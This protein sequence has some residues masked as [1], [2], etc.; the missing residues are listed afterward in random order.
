MP[1]KTLATIGLLVFVTAICVLWG[2][3]H[4]VQTRTFDPVDMPVSLQPGRIQT[5]AFEIN[6]PESYEVFIHFDPSLDDYY[7]E[8][9]CS[10]KNLGSD[11]WKVFRLVRGSSTERQLWASYND[12][13]DSLR[14]N[15]FEAVPGRY[16]VEW[17]VPAGAAC[18]NI[19]HP[20]LHVSTYADEYLKFA[21]LTQYPCLFIGGTGAML[22]L[23]ALFTWLLPLFSK[24]QQL[25]IFPE[26]VLKN[27]I[28]PRRHRPIPLMRDTSNFGVVWG[29]ILY[30]LMFLFAMN[31]P[32]PS[33]GLLLNLKQAKSAAAQPS[34]WAEMTSVYISPTQFYVNGKP[35]DRKELHSKLLESLSKQMV[36]TVYF[37]AHGDCTFQE[38]AYAMDTIQ[39]LG[40]KVVWITPKIREALAEAAKH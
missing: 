17:D 34:P 12:S 24:K 29:S 18:L 3:N 38:A 26:L 6:L 23:R 22:A 5:G 10:Y 39:G 16:E 9:R 15:Q 1:Q 27:V 20:R 8:G 28:A 14:A 13:D 25:R 36:W 35:I 33:F 31:T 30:V 37:E 21:A 32:A 40:A 19:R 4:W 7:A 11:R 2:T